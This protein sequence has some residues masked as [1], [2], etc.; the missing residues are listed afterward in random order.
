M[1]LTLTYDEV[2]DG[3]VK[4]IKDGRNV[5]LSM[6]VQADSQTMD[7]ALSKFRGNKNVVAIQYTGDMSDLPAFAI[8]EDCPK[9]FVAIPVPKL[10]EYV[11][12]YMARLDKRAY[13]VFEVPETYFDLRMAEYFCQKYPN[14]R[15][16]GGNFYNI[17]TVRLGYV[18]PA[19]IPRKIADSRVAKIAQGK[20]NLVTTYTIG[21]LDEVIFSPLKV[22][23]PLVRGGKAPSVPKAPKA[24]RVP[25]DPKPPREKKQRESAKPKAKTSLVSLFGGQQNDGDLF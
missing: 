6:I 19:W 17:T 1:L 7:F 21:E 25:K 11:D 9:V 12:A 10:E 8:E 20:R 3:T 14:L 23:I 13:A 22:S 4:G 15:V 16:T 18:D 24:P 5:L 2:K